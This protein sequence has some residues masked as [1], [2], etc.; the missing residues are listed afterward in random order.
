M[1]RRQTV[2]AALRAWRDAE[3]RLESAVDGDTEA[4]TR[5]VAQ[6]RDAYQQLSAESMN[7]WMAKL[8]E[9]EGR[10]ANATP[11]T[12][13]FHEAAR[14]TQ[15]IASQ[16]WEAARSSDEDTPET[17]VNRR[18]TPRPVAPGSR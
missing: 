13:P 16:I 9:A 7:E 3:R 17:E 1:E 4:L 14:D 12:L 18:R 15:E 6:L 11:S 8:D 5:E 2:E 10:R